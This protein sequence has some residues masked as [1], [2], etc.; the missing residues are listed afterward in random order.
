MRWL[1]CRSRAETNDTL[2]FAFF[3]ARAHTG[4]ALGRWFTR[5]RPYLRKGDVAVFDGTYRD[6]R[7]EMF[8]SSSEE[9]IKVE[10]ERVDF[11]AHRRGRGEGKR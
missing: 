9:R 10:H 5:D 6:V 4:P 2:F 1:T 11:G 3:Q 8:P 7:R